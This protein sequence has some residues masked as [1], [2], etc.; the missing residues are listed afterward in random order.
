[1]TFRIRIAAAS[2]VVA[3]LALT[4]CGTPTAS[5]GTT[6]TAAPTTT[7]NPNA[8][9]DCSPPNFHPGANFGVS[10]DLSG[11]TIEKVDLSPSG[12]SGG[13]SGNQTYAPDAHLEGTT[14]ISSNLSYANFKYPHAAGAK[15]VSSNFTGIV[16]VGGGESSRNDL[17]GTTWTEIDA[18]SAELQY[19]DLSGATLI[20]VKLA[21]AHLEGSLWIKADLSGVTVDDSTVCPDGILYDAVALCRGS[22]PGF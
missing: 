21:G 5:G 10:C 9:P 13:P 15:F 18:T 16:L 22:L 7:T 3:A 20:N 1:M 6:T 12:S 11:I 19:A 4:G 8:G 17:T 2:T 14:I